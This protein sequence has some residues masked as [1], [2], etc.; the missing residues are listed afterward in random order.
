ME[1]YTFVKDKVPVTFQ[2]FY[3]NTFNEI[4]HSTNFCQWITFEIFFNEH[5]NTTSSTSSNPYDVMVVN[6]TKICHINNFRV[7]PS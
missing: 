7:E 6:F 3:K 2:T 5:T 1:V 4:N